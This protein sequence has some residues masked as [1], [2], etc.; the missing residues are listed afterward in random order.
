MNLKQR[1]FLDVYEQVKNHRPALAKFDHVSRKYAEE[2][3][4][5]T[6]SQDYF[7]AIEYAKTK[8]GREL[9]LTTPGSLDPWFVSCRLTDLAYSRVNE[10]R[11]WLV[12]EGYLFEV[13]IKHGPTKVERI[14]GVTPK[15]LSVSKQYVE[16]QKKEQGGH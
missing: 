11:S 16:L 7:D 10:A 9:D 2:L 8:H 12:S 3:A 15:G 5:D 6:S 1:V 13:K 14:Y 4:A